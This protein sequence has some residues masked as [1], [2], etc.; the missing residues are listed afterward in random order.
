MMKNPLKIMKNLIKFEFW[1]DQ[2]FPNISEIENILVKHLAMKAEDD[3]GKV[4]IFS[5]MK[6][7]YSKQ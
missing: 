7:H 5:R 3:N 2:N 4:G 1:Y 6:T